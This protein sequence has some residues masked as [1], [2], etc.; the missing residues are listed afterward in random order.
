LGIA[1]SAYARKGEEIMHRNRMFEIEWPD[2]GVKVTA[3]MLEREAPK[4]STVIWD[5]MPFDSICIHTF[6]SGQE[7]I[8]PTPDQVW[9]PEVRE[10]LVRED[11]LKP[12]EM[13]FSHSLTCN[14]AI[15]YGKTTEPMYNPVFAKVNDED[16]ET[17]VQVGIKVWQNLTQMI[18]P[19]RMRYV[20]RALKTTFRKK[21][22]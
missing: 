14:I 22:N 21:E 3:R 4:I 8:I 16:L 12:G 2:L 20:K 11:L 15:I 19:V 6:I 7:L 1:V 5:C 9:M 10:N 13:Y 17:L 18:D